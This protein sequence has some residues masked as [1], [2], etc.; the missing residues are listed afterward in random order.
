MNFQVAF[1]VCVCDF[2]LKIK[3]KE[4]SKIVCFMSYYNFP[5]ANE[6]PN[7]PTL[8]PNGDGR[9]IVASSSTRRF[10]TT[11]PKPSQQL[12]ALF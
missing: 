1:D 10:N 12:A 4:K 3:L 11:I 8:V 5:M 7:C 9:I 6:S 2:C